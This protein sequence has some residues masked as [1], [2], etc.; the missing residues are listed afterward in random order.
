MSH[1]TEE[2]PSLNDTK[3]RLELVNHLFYYVVWK[4]IHDY[5]STNYGLELENCCVNTLPRLA[6]Y[7]T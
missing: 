3:I 2:D 7:F 1:P 4:V 5:E 6:G